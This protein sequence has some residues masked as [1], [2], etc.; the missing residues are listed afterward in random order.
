ML[1]G[2]LHK[3]NMHI[4]TESAVFTGDAL[5]LSPI[6]NVKLEVIMYVG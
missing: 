6:K 4:L 5:E 2:F 1:V 3:L